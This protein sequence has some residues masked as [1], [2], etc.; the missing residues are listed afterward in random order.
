MGKPDT[1]TG[2][3]EA[4]IASSS[5]VSGFAWTKAAP[6]ENASAAAT[7]TSAAS[8][9]GA[10]GRGRETR[11][12]GGW[13]CVTRRSD[14]RTDRRRNAVDRRNPM[15]E[16]GVG[17]LRLNPGTC[18]RP[19]AGERGGFEAWNEGRCVVLSAH[20]GPTRPEETRRERTQHSASQRAA[21]RSRVRFPTAPASPTERHA[22][23]PPTDRRDINGRICDVC[24]V[25]LP[26]G[27][28]RSHQTGA[29]DPRCAAAEP[30]T[31]SPFDLPHITV[32]STDPARPNRPR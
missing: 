4:E 29:G 16:S 23:V 9:A 12:V 17:E 28:S 10:P 26:L 32:R 31:R 27:E 6:P 19:V 21:R 20:G 15:P 11:Q 8:A 13:A 2:S 5:E 14:G 7:S 1:S 3:C 18:C 25:P 24:V 30:F 22:L